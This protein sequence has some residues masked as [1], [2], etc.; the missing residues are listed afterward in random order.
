MIGAAVVEHGVRYA[1]YV[2]SPTFSAFNHLSETYSY[3]APTYNLE[4]VH[5]F[6]EICK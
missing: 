5:E 1:T 2:A 3:C 6:S 4:I